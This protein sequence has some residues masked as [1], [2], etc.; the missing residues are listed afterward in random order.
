MSD[1]SAGVNLSLGTLLRK[2]S[3][4]RT[5]SI[6]VL[7]AVALL[8]GYPIG[9]VIVEIFLRQ[10]ALGLN[11]MLGALFASDIPRVIGDTALAVALSGALAMVFGATFAWLNQRTDASTGWVGELLPLAPLLVPQIAGVTGWV[12]LLAPQAG[13]V[14]GLLRALFDAVGFHM[15]SGPVDIYSFTGLVCIMALYLVPYAYLTT[16][17]AFQTLDPHLEEASRMCRAGALTT[18]RRI[19]LPAIRP[20][21]FAAALLLIMMGFSMFS[22]PVIIGSGARID[23]LSV[24]IYR[25]IVSYPPRTDLAIVL[26]VELTFIVQLTLLLRARIS[27]S[28]QSAALA[29]KGLR[30]TPVALG[31]WRPFARGVMIFYLLATAVV[32]VIG[33]AFVSLQPFWTAHINW[34]ALGFQNY[35]AVLI[36]N[37]MT[38]FALFNSVLLGIVGGTVGMMIAALLTVAGHASPRLRKSVDLITAMPAGIPHVVLA[39]GFIL[40]FSSGWLNLNGTL[41]ILLLVYLVINLPQAMAAAAA[42]RSAIGP[43]LIE[44]AQIFKATPYGSFRRILLPLMLPGLAGGWIILFVQMSGELTASALLSGTT[45]PVIGQTILD[46]WNNGSFPQIAALAMTMTAI[47]AVVVFAALRFSRLRI[48]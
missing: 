39:I 30:A 9:T 15:R 45:N 2:R 5:L 32:P 24:R 19:T 10:G 47:N 37:E 46:F 13:V 18:L 42:A 35:R 43:E 3:S 4:L 28:G 33:L 1:I 20:A 25:L 12:I 17:A 23:L 31:A 44:A 11:D 6:L 22:V 26:G 7:A 41:T 8:I 14:N 27:G 21:L 38:R 16:L 48:S 40:C 34:S 29:G 36:Q